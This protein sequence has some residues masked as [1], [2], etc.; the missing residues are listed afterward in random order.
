METRLINPLE[1]SVPTGYS[2]VAVAPAG[3][4]IFVSG[5]IAYDPTGRVVGKG[6]FR[7]QA[8]QVY[9]NLYAALAAADA[10]FGDVAKMTTFVVDLTPER[11]TVMRETRARFLPEN[12]R[13]ASTM[14]G[15]T[16]LVNPDL[17]VEVEV[18]AVLPDRR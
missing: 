10:T 14:V 16:S 7:A 12:H 5:Q 13:P 9:Q 2:H 11:A 17:L 4:T 6:D 3:R 18:I 15:V 1:L 8:E